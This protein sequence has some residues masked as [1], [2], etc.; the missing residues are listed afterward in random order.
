MTA[1]MYTSMG[2][3]SPMMYPARHADRPSI[4]DCF[5]VLHNVGNAINDAYEFGRAMAAGVVVGAAQLVS[6]RFSEATCPQV[7]GYTT[8]H[9]VAWCM[10]ELCTNPEHELTA[11]C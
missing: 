4:E 8:L 11:C 3:T 5:M 2:R 9:L 1:A 7:C 10:S 6:A